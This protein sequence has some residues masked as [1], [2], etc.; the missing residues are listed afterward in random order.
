MKEEELFTLL[1]KA[2]TNLMTDIDPE[3]LD[4]WSAGED[5]IGEW[6]AKDN[7]KFKGFTNEQARK[8]RIRQNRR[9][10]E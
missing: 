8:Y 4:K 3:I 1:N 2:L 6:Y 5:V 9:K 7:R 10:K